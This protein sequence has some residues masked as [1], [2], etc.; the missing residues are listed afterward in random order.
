MIG[1]VTCPVSM[2]VTRSLPLTGTPATRGLAEV[3]QGKHSARDSR[4]G[5]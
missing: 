5:T 3:P 1:E 2:A 4:K